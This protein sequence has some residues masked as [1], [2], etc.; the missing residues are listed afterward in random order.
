MFEGNVL[1]FSAPPLQV[2]TGL[3]VAAG[4]KHHPDCVGLMFLHVSDWVQKGKVPEKD[5]K[6]MGH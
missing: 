6:Y 4:R 3:Q 5:A 1:A 2:A